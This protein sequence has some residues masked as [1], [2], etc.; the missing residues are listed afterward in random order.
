MSLAVESGGMQD[1]EIP[2]KQKEL[3]GCCWVPSTVGAS[4]ALLI[5]G[6][7]ARENISAAHPA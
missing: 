5:G 4:L 1:T 6:G 2:Y 7:R 3:R